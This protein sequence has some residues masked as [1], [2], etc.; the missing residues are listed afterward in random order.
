M[1]DLDRNIQASAPVTITGPD[2]LYKADVIR[3]DNVNKMLV[4]AT[5]VPDTV[6]ELIFER[7]KDGGGVGSSNL[8]VNGSTTQVTFQIN[9]HPTKKKIIRDIK[10]NAF[11]GGIKVDTFLGQNS[12]LTNGV[13]VRLSVNGIS[14]DFLP[15][16]TTQDFDGHFAYGDGARFDIVTASGNDSMV[17]VFSPREPIVLSAGSVDKVSIIIRDNLT[18]ISFFECVAF[19]L[20]D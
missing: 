12:P 5:T 4:K 14:Q 17:A 8:A 18:N 15:I 6:S 19:G 10:F 16:K 13:V 9:A 20:F 3:E 7:F 2:E 1:G 11:D